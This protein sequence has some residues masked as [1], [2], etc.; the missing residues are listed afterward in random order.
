[1]KRC[2]VC[3]HV[4]NSP[5]GYAGYHHSHHDCIL[6]DVILCNDF[7]NKLTHGYREMKK[8]M[9]KAYATQDECKAY[10]L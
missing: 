8:D 2:D 10:E 4:H 7:I 3:N 1:M 6:D 9:K 5:C